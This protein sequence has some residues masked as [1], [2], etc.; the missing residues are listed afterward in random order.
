MWCF[1]MSTL[2]VDV[3]VAVP[4]HTIF[5]TLRLPPKTSLRN[6]KLDQVS[7]RGWGADCGGVLRGAVSG[8]PGEGWAAG[9][10][11]LGRHATRRHVLI[12]RRPEVHSAPDPL[13]HTRPE[14][15][16]QAWPPDDQSLGR[17]VARVR[18]R[19]YHHAV[20]GA[21]QS[22]Q[23][24]RNG[25]FKEQVLQQARGDVFQELLGHSPSMDL[26]DGIARQNLQGIRAEHRD[27]ALLLRWGERPPDSSV[28]RCREAGRQRNDQEERRGGRKRPV[29]HPKPRLFKLLPRRGGRGP[30]KSDS[31]VR[32]L[33]EAGRQRRD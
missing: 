7:E 16:A 25:S 22:P 29:K 23:R 17:G 1:I 2:Q 4:R 11:L 8:W 18:H 24:R 15:D 12:Q 6:G 5:R 3:Q 28:R 26:Q 9:C 27:H 10:R 20:R 31:S 30:P 13:G 21:E 32:W 19:R 33:R 14:E